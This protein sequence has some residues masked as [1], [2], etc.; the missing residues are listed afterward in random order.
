MTYRPRR[1]PRLPYTTLSRSLLERGGVHITQ[2]AHAQIARSLLAVGAARRVL[3]VDVGMLGA[4]V[5]DQQRQ[6]LTCQRSEEHTSELQSRGHLVC[7][8]LLEKKKQDTVR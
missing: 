8:P 2:S 4:G 1:S 3:P 7:R 5:R 6:V